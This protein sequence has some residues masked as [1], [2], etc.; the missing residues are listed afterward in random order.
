MKGNGIGIYYRVNGQRESERM[1]N[2]GQI[3][4]GHS[5]H[6]TKERSAKIKD[7]CRCKVNAKADAEINGRTRLEMNNSYGT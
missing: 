7:I 3:D 1:Y 2:V 6:H 4:V 5:G